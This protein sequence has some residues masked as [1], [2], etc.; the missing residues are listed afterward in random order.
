MNDQFSYITRF[1][2]LPLRWGKKKE[3]K[4]TLVLTAEKESKFP[5]RLHLGKSSIA[6]G[7]LP[8]GSP[9]FGGIILVLTRKDGQ[10]PNFFLD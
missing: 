10:K 9:A 6:G 5:C 3:F 1:F 7:F 4:S 2:F 8:K